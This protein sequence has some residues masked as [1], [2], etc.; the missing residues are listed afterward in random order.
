MDIRLINSFKDPIKNTIAAAKTCYSSKGIVYPD[1]IEMSERDNEIL[2]NIYKGGHH[3]TFQH[4]YLQFAID[5]VSRY[6]VITFLHNHPFYNSEEVSQRY[7]RVQ[8]QNMVIPSFQNQQCTGLF[9]KCLELQFEAYEELIELLTPHI[10]ENYFKIFPG[11]LKKEEKYELQIKRLARENARYILPL[12]SK[13]RLYHTV[14][15]ITL[16]RYYRVCKII[17]CCSKEQFILVNKMI[18]ALLEVDPIFANII[19]EPLDTPI[20]SIEPKDRKSVINGFDS[21]FEEY[22]F[23]Y[24]MNC[25]GASSKYDVLMHNIVTQLNPYKNNMLAETLDLLSFGNISKILPI[26][27]FSFMKRISMASFAQS[28]RHRTIDVLTP[29][30]PLDSFV[31][32]P[33]VIV[34][35]VIEDLSVAKNKYLDTVDI[36]YNYVREII[37]KSNLDVFNAMY[38]LPTGSVVRFVET[39]NLLNYRHKYKMRLCY[40]SQYEIWKTSIEEVQQITNKYP[41]MGELLLPPCGIHNLAKIKPTCPEG[42]RFCGID[43]WNLRHEEYKR[44]Y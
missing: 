34:P 5:G 11:R 6:L 3:T 23:S 2:N 28:Q 21:V 40:L 17:G 12:A 16:L 26:V 38:L 14:N 37:N 31:G 33:D 36:I 32:T 1:E 39:G 13:T 8:K 15:V 9:E 20:E 24:L 25:D 4:Q 43:V 29:V 27:K 30:F 18:D 22:K 19:Q 41:E 7:V 42:E 10:R 44:S 35:K